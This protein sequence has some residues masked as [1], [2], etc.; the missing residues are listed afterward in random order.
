MAVKK[1]REE[2]MSGNVT[3]IEVKKEWKKKLKEKM[4]K[5]TKIQNRKG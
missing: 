5:N 1:G 3:R 2:E 4:E